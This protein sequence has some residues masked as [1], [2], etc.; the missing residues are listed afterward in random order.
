V[1]KCQLL[2]KNLEKVYIFV[3]IAEQKLLLMTI[4][5]LYRLAQNVI[6]QNLI[7]LNLKINRQTLFPI[8]IFLN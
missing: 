5:I 7:E 1:Y 6:I 3:K 4:M 2:V 8:T